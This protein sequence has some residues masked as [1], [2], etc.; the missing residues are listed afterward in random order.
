MSSNAGL[1]KLALACMDQRIS[2]TVLGEMTHIPA[3]LLS[4]YANGRRR[5]SRRHTYI[6]GVALNIPAT[7]LRG[8]ATDD[9][10][11]IDEEEWSENHPLPKRNNYHLTPRY[12]R[13]TVVG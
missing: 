12:T 8:Y 9:Q 10:I 11:F 2:L 1:T 6:L 13:I 3:P 5:I 4:M 7:E